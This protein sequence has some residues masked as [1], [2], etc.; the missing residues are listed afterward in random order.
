MPDRL[1]VF[2]YGTLKPGERY[3]DRYCAD[4]VL[5]IQEAIVYGQ[6]YD[7]SLGY[8]AMTLGD[9]LVYG[10]LL[11]FADQ[12]V[13]E[14]LDELEDYSPHRP[15]EENE[16][17]RIEQETFGVELQPLGRAWIYVMEQERVKRL[18]GVL[19]PEGRWVSRK[20]DTLFP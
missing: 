7:L 10:M 16:Y 11:S 5:A 8:P 19:L 20:M 3:Y 9:R 15:S 13:L 2:T 4:K 17:L 18:K 1:N 12:K 6:L 14:A